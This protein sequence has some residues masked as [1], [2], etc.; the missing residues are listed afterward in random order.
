M[1]ASHLPRQFPESNSR[2]L[3]LRTNRV[4][5]FVERPQW[6]A[7]VR[8][9]TVSFACFMPRDMRSLRAGARAM[10]RFSVVMGGVG[11]VSAQP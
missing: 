4:Q 10:F 1:F 11:P 5:T 8:G 3:R 6:V 2:K 7:E 9:S